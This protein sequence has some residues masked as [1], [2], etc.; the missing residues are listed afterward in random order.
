MIKKVNLNNN[1]KS[2]SQTSNQP[3]FKGLNTKSTN[4]LIKLGANGGPIAATMASCLAIGTMRPLLLMTDKDLK[5][6]DKVYSAF[7]YGAVS[8]VSMGLLLL[9]KK[10]LENGIFKLASKLLKNKPI[11]TAYF[12][13]DKAKKGLKELT[14]DSLLNFHEAQKNYNNIANLKGTNGQAVLGLH[15][16][17]TFFSNM[18]IMV[19]VANLITKYLKPVINNIFPKK[20]NDKS[21]DCDK[22]IIKGPK[23]AIILTGFASI[24]SLLAL[25]KIP[26]FSSKMAESIKKIL[27]QLKI[28]NNTT[29]TGKAGKALE[30]VGSMLKETSNSLWTTLEI[31]VNGFSR[32]A[33]LSSA[34]QYF[35]AINTGIGEGINFLLIQITKPVTKFIQRQSLQ[36][37]PVHKRLLEAAASQKDSIIQNLSKNEIK[38][39]YVGEGVKTAVDMLVT[40]FLTLGIL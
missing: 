9:Y 15:K 25:S 11:E 18:F 30:K 31:G 36:N 10:P 21:D 28:R 6:D 22:K 27:P 24:V 5:K 17:M 29:N 35:S 40:N 7:W 3:A 13:L 1:I 2:E 4:A 16:I 12:N 8:A 14:N 39:F 23:D 20:N 34:K 19:N 26:G 33:I 38:Q 37:N 32:F